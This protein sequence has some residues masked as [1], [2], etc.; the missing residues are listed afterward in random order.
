MTDRL[1]EIG[2]RLARATP[3]PWQTDGL[4]PK[5]INDAG[6]GNMVAR[7]MS[8]EPY[9]PRQYSD[10]EFIGHAPADIGWLVSEVERLRK[11][12]EAIGQ[13]MSHYAVEMRTAQLEVERLRALCGRA[14]DYLDPAGQPAPRDVSPEALALLCD[15]VEARED[16]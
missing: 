10:A 7:T 2:A 4:D 6:R 5:R 3:G 15:L 16:V 9:P 11:D 13:Q 1:A 14:A 12:C 8:N